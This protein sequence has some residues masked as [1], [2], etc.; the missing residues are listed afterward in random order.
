MG[1]VGGHVA[2]TPVSKDDLDKEMEDYRAG[3]IGIAV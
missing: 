1:R 3:A 2:K